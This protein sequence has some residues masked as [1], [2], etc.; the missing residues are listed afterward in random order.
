MGRRIVHLGEAENAPQALTFRH[1][2][3]AP[4]SDKGTSV[5]DVTFKDPRPT[6]FV[7]GVF[8]HEQYVMRM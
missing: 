2:K 3:R 7:T 8:L 5:M 6:S 1:A 4:T